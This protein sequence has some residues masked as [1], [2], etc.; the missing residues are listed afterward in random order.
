MANKSIPDNSN[1]SKTSRIPQNHTINFLNHEDIYATAQKPQTNKCKI[2]LYLQG[3]FLI[4]Q[5][6]NAF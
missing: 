6:K 1:V 5:S 4:S 2:F 3:Y